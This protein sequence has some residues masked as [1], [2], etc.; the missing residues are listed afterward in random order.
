MRLYCTEDKKKT[1][2]F[3]H[4][5]CNEKVVN[6]IVIKLTCLECGINRTALIKRKKHNIFNLFKR[7]RLKRCLI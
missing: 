2:W 4:P 5:V 6:S 3:P 1:D 7:R